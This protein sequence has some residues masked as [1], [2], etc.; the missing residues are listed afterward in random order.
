[1]FH[2]K[3][4]LFLPNFKLSDKKPK[5]CSDMCEGKKYFWEG[6]EYIT[7]WLLKSY[8]LPVLAP[9]GLKKFFNVLFFSP[10]KCDFFAIL[11]VFNPIPAGGGVPCEPGLTFFGDISKSITG[12]RLFK[13]FDI[14]TNIPLTIDW[15]RGLF[16]YT[17]LSSGILPEFQNLHIFRFPWIQ[18]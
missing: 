3:I 4:H 1:M 15:K 14:L 13:F 7:L 17:T 9:K 12:L 6:G 8:S 5:K 11:N 16:T 18:I 2:K 10:K